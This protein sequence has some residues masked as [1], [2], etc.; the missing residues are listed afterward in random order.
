[1]DAL[2][3]LQEFASY[4]NASPKNRSPPLVGRADGSTSPPDGA[5]R[6]SQQEEAGVRER[7][8]VVEQLELLRTAWLPNPITMASDAGRRDSSHR[9]SPRHRGNA[10]RSLTSRTGGG[11]LQL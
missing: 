2:L 3:T 8:V 11:T 10:R 9:A 7:R 5:V 4:L 6:Q 1:M